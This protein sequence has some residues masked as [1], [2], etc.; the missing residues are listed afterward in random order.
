MVGIFQFKPYTCPSK[1]W[2]G[3]RTDGQLRTIG[4]KGET[5][6]RVLREAGVRLIARRGFEAMSLRMLA[7][8]VG[9]QA[10]SLYN[11]FDNKQDFL[12]DLLASIIRDL[13]DEL[14]EKLAGIE[15][16]RDRLRA[17]VQE[18]IN[19]HTLRK[20]EVFIGN[21]EL[22]SLSPAHHREIRSMRDDYEKVLEDIIRDGVEAGYFK[23]A[24]IGT[25]KLAIL[26]MLTGV[27]TWYRPS[28]RHTIVTL[29]EQYVEFTFGLLHAQDHVQEGSRVSHREPS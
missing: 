19:F 21:M 12:F 27:S 23:C 7:K 3:L 5:T 29:I 14:L 17:F 18:H 8:E 13:V 24:D 2:V 16:P 28:G 26:A 11:Y 1:G 9:V 15:D 4:S 22:R 6:E 25:A 10:G 20:E